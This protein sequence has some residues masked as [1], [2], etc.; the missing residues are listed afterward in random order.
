MGVDSGI[1]LLLRVTRDRE[2]CKSMCSRGKAGGKWGKWGKGANVAAEQGSQG[3]SLD[4]LM[5]ERLRDK[6][7][8]CQTMR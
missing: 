4:R 3:R 8:A 7:K 5:E 6:Q 1:D 2:K